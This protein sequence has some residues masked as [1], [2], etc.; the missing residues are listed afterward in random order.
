MKR[1]LKIFNGFGGRHYHW[2]FFG[3]LAIAN[4]GFSMVFGSPNHWFQW[5][6]MVKY[7]WSNNRMVSMDWSGL[8]Q[9]SLRSTA[10]WDWVSNTS[11]LSYSVCSFNLFNSTPPT[12]CKET[13]LLTNYLY[14]RGDTVFALELCIYIWCI[15]GA[16]IFPQMFRY[17]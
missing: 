4:D 7:H 16:D 12:Q 15:S 13:F 10:V 6:S 5:F 1:P 3:T 14:L 17:F 9:I 2:M 8:I 11:T